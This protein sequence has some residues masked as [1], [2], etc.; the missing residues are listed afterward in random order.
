MLT[1]EQAKQIKDLGDLASPDQKEQLKEF[2]AA[3]NET[4]GPIRIT[5]EEWQNALRN[6]MI[7]LQDLP[8][9]IKSATISFSE[10]RKSKRTG[11]SYLL[12]EVT[13]LPTPVVVPINQLVR[14]KSKFMTN[15][16]PLVKENDDGDVIVKH[17]DKY[18]LT[19]DENNWELHLK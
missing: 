18:A 17:S 5:K 10:K 2:E 7:I 19:S 16:F 11:N 3:Q 14:W 1:K 4:G 9:G 12:M 15:G 6:T 13:G 8:G